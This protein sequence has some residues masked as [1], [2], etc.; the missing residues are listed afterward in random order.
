MSKNK[1]SIA[2]LVSGGIDSSCLLAELASQYEEVF[3]VYIRCG[4]RWEGAE[5]HALQ[6]L[7]EA[8]EAPSLAP[9]M[10]LEAPMRDLHAQHW[11]MTG[12]EVPDE[13]SD[14]SAVY[15][16]GRNLLL[17]SKA[18]VFCTQ[19]KVDKIALGLLKGNP[20]PDATENFFKHLNAVVKEALHARLTIEGPY[21][22]RT[23][24]E[25]LAKASKIIPLQLTFSC[26]NPVEFYHCGVCNKCA[27]RQK[28]FAAAKVEDP[29]GYVETKVKA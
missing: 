14:P 26:L 17:V 16:P 21:L 18:A 3:P 29:T 28:A 25:I 19:Q 7:L 12:K 5:L 22:G 23:K 27:E 13:K 1:K 9:L 2:V 8:I 10:I 24:K 11:T 20:F 4:Y 6:R 15:L